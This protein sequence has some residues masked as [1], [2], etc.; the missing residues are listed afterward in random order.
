M[1]LTIIINGAIINFEIVYTTI[2][3]VN[4]TIEYGLSGLEPTL[5]LFELPFRRIF[6]RKYKVRIKITKKI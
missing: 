2:Y 4:R 1:I 3:L 6:A 5:N